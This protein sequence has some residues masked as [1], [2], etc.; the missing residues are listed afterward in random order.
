MASETE[1]A[2][3]AAV[4]IGTSSRISTLDDDRTLARVLKAVWPAERRATIRDGAWNWAMRRAALPSSTPADAATI[5]PW[6]YRF[7]LPGDCLRIVD[8]IDASSTGDWIVEDGAILSDLP[9]P[10]RVRYMVDVVEPA[11]WDASFAEAFARRLAMTCGNRIAGSAFSVD[12]AQEAYRMAISSAKRV[13]AGEN[14]GIE[15]AE[16]SWIEARWL[17]MPAGDGGWR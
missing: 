14:P 17:N 8:I 7:P 13:D 15:Q 16:S 9:A 1:I 6:S 5:H 12:R 11:Q 4:F 3:L 2:N 10:L